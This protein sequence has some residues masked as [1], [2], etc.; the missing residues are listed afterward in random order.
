[1]KKNVQTLFPTSIVHT[2]LGLSRSEIK[3]LTLEAFQF[4]KSDT[5]GRSWSEK[6]YFE[7]YTSYASLPPLSQI[8]SSFLDL[9]KLIDQ[10]VNAFTRH[11]DMDLPK[12]GL[13]LSSFWIN[14]MREHCTHSSHLHP[15]SVISG[16]FYLQTP[17][18]SSGLKFEDP[19]LPQMMASPPR[20][21]KAHPSNQRFITIN[22]KEG[23]LILFESYL[24]H[25]VPPHR[26]K[27]P[28]ISVSFNYDWI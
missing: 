21:Q 13:T 4:E 28:R 9:K 27:I 1:M 12:N 22:P 20:K 14:I 19:R 8:S 6:N 11:L 25:E 5:V 15:L 2:P 26:L 10:Q 17:K 24:K 18:G 16:T 3:A 23:D 7:G